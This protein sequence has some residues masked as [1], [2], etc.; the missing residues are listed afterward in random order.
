MKQLEFKFRKSLTNS[1]WYLEYQDNDTIHISIHSSR[2][3]AFAK[4]LRI[5]PLKFLKQFTVV[6]HWED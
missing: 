3:K 1:H 2:S 5:M 6:L 4:M